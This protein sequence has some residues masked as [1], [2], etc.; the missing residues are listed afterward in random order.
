MFFKSKTKEK[1]IYLPAGELSFSELKNCMLSGDLV[2]NAPG[3]EEDDNIIAHVDHSSA[4]E[5]E[6]ML[7]DCYITHKGKYGRIGLTVSD[8]LF[9]TVYYNMVFIAEDGSSENLGCI[10][11]AS[12]GG[13][14]GIPESFT[15]F[16]GRKTVGDGVYFLSRKAFDGEEDFISIREYSTEDGM[17][18]M[19]TDS[20]IYAPTLLEYG[21]GED[22]HFAEINGNPLNFPAPKSPEPKN[23]LSSRFISKYT[24]DGASFGFTLPLSGLDDSGVSAKIRLDGKQY[25]LRIYAGSIKSEPVE[26]EGEE[27]IL[28]CDRSFARVFFEKKSGGA[29]TPPLSSEYNNLEVTAYKTEEAHKQSVAAMSRAKKLA[30]SVLE[31]GEAVTVFWGSSLSPQ[32]IILN[33][34]KNPLYFPK[35]SAVKLGE[36][37]ELHD[38]ITLGKRLYIFKGN[39]VYKSDIKAVKDVA[40]Y[41]VSLS[42]FCSLPTS[43]AKNTVASLSDEILFAD[44]F[45][46]VYSINTSSLSIKRICRMEAPA[47]FAAEFDGKYL[48][49]KEDTALV[50]QKRGN[51]FVQGSW[52][53]PKSCVGIF[54]AAGEVIFFFEKISGGAVDIIA[55]KLKEEEKTAKAAL[56]FKLLEEKGNIRLNS[57]TLIGKGGEFTLTSFANG[58]LSASRR[59]SLKEGRA[60]VL[61]GSISEELSI[62]L[63]FKDAFVLEKIKAQYIK[64]G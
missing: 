63:T 2:K 40:V 46:S 1:E 19:L 25:T 29:W 23:L 55:A 43:P 11:F 4:Y 64:K 41:P 24:T 14:I 61:V 45:G 20:S 50:L 62:R 3:F 18:V 36:E 37:G 31:G 56:E 58:R 30:G 35:D 7:T 52:S 34:P 17:W 16:S 22:Y 49:V 5:T 33:S 6:F 13:E 12:N 28:Y 57:V 9:G 38:L 54:S 60:K 53:F 44:R 15:V 39:E 47:D 10:Q 26:I 32:S 21:R 59:G 48:L 8:N 42:Y 27:V 51:G